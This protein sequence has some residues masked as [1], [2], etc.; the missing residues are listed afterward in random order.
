MSSSSS[1]E[2]N[3]SAM[4]EMTRLH[5]SLLTN[6]WQAHEREVLLVRLLFCLFA[7][8][9]EIFPEGSFFRY[10]LASREDGRDLAERLNAL[11]IVLDTAPEG[12]GD[13]A[14]EL[15]YFPYI[16]GKLFAEPLSAGNLDGEFRRI[17]LEGHALSW[18]EISPEIFGAMF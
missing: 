1:R 5:E 14:E 15:L 11:F 13:T 3:Q 4:E 12:R 18:G 2:I 7:D 9:T 10:V 17:L 8:D 6:G 16:N